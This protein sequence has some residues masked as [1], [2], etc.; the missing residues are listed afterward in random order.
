MPIVVMPAET[1]QRLKDRILALGRTCEVKM[2]V[3]NDVVLELQF[4]KSE[5]ER[6]GGAGGPAIVVAVKNL[7]RLTRA[8][9]PSEGDVLNYIEVKNP[10]ALVR[11]DPFAAPR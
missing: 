8:I 9:P 11:L 1:A 3:A 2:F 7:A 4:T 5:R 6:F 10:K